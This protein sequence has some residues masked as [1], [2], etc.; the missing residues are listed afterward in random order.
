MKYSL[1]EKLKISE[2][3]VWLKNKQYKVVGPKAKE[4]QFVYGDLDSPDELK[5]EHKPPVLAL[6][7]YYLPQEENLLNFSFG[8]TK[9]KEV[10]VSNNFTVVF[11]AHTCDIAGVICLENACDIEPKDNNF[12]ERN[13]NIL[14]IGIEC[15]KPCDEYA[16]CVTMG[17][18]NPKG[19]YDLMLTDIGNQYLVHV[20]SQEGLNVVA[21]DKIFV[22]ADSEYIS[23]VNR[24]RTDKT[25]VF[26][27]Q[28][29][30]AENEIGV[31]LGRTVKSPV[32]DDIG[33]RCLSCGNCTNV[34]PTCYCFD[35]RDE[36]NLAVTEGRRYRVWDS[37]QLK[38]FAEVAGGENFR[39]DRKKRQQHRLFRKFKYPIE[40]Y[41]R[42]FCVGCGRCSRTCMAKISLI[43]TINSLAKESI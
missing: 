6:K 23:K 18:H 37:C 38:E 42:N 25:N 13:K 7:K 31:L 28:L 20:N 41:N 39:K 36:V 35:V 32:W 16:T 26:N 5:L 14:I 21:N 15:L 4:N 34:C 19:G 40:K 43:E 1:I 12:F 10:D 22:D 29:N 2:L 30:V 17:T 33:K 9:G 27:K 24:I 11:G 8:E 3:V